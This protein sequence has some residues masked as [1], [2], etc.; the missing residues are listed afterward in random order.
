ML[1]G[2]FNERPPVAKYSN[3]WNVSKVLRHLNGLDENDTLSLHLLTIKSVMLMAL[4]RPARS[5]D[6]YYV[7][8]ILGHAPFHWKALRNFK[9]QHVSKQSRASKPLADFF[10]P[11]YPEDHTI[12]PVVTLQEYEARTKEFRLG[13]QRIGK[14]CCSCPGEGNIT[15]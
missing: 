6:L 2:V 1:K 3:F 10:Y 9:A 4:T 13:Q 15:Q 14:S 11:R 8:W 12:C 7:N 5:V